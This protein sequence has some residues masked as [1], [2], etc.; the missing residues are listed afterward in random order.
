MRVLCMILT[1]SLVNCQNEDVSSWTNGRYTTSRTQDPVLGETLFLSVQVT[2][3]PNEVW[4]VECTVTTPSGEL[5]Q[6][7][8]NNVY[9]E[10]GDTVPG[11]EGE[12]TKDQCWVSVASASEEHL[13]D[14]RFNIYDLIPT[15]QPS[16]VI[17]TANL[18][19]DVRLPTTFTPQHYGV[20]LIPDFDSTGDNITYEGSMTMSLE[21]RYSDN[22]LLTFHMDELTLVGE[23]RICL[24]SNCSVTPVT[25]TIY[26]FQ[27]TFV[28][29]ETSAPFLSGSVYEL[30]LSFTAD[31][32]RGRYFT[33]GFYPQVCSETNG[34]PK[35]CWFTQGESTTMRNAF[36]CLDEPAL[37]ATFSLEVARTEDYFTR[38]NTPLIDTVPLP[39]K[40]GYVLDRF[41]T[42]PK[43]SAYLVAIGITDFVSLPSLDDSTTVWGPRDDIEAGRGDYANQIGSEIMSYYADYFK[44]LYPLAKMDLMYE[45]KKGGAMENWGLVLFAPR[46]IMLDADADDEA[47]WLVTN[48]ISHELAHQVDML[49]LFICSSVHTDVRCKIQSL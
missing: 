49:T 21:S 45:A 44:V 7:S 1:L 34:D 28:H 41:E 4:D 9:G 27:R 47:K 2:G 43:M 16:F 37:K 6:V 10:D 31:L 38:T 46:T 15:P 26:D 19:T 3:E 14:W 40:P 30:S 33:Y 18:V 35:L 48:V 8:F 13:G 42:T 29:L 17:T 11:V 36:P 22:N 32:S 5:W 24:Q 39:E 20:R 12:F 23:P 25:R